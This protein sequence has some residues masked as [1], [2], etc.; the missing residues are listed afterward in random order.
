MTM[1]VLDRIFTLLKERGMVQ[2]ELAR[3]LGIHPDTPTKWKKGIS[4]SYL[5][6]LPQ[7]AAVLGTTPEYLLT[8]KKDPA[9]GDG[10]GEVGEI[11]RLLAQLSPERRAK[12][13]AYLEELVARGGE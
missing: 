2:K 4:Q 13:V 12:E 7:I 1:D 3:Q 10:D 8:G 5:K 6:M 11:M 9:T